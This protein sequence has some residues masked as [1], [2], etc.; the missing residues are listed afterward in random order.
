VEWTA[1][2]LITDRSATQQETNSTLEDLAFWTET[3]IG[4]TLG[5]QGTVSVAGVF[6]APNASPFTMGGG[7][8]QTGDTDAQFIARSLA[9]NGAG[10]LFLRPDPRNSIVLPA[11]ANYAL[12]R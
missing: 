4:N 11:P 9:A 3:A 7:T 5:G 12:V 6:S 1:P 8:S 2:N 10:S